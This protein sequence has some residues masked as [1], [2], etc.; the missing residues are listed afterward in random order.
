MGGLQSLD[1]PPPNPA[2]LREGRE[3]CW[4]L[5]G[6]EREA[7]LQ[8]D[9]E[10]L[11]TGTLWSGLSPVPRQGISPKATQT[12]IRH[13]V[14]EAQPHAVPTGHSMVPW[15]PASPRDFLHSLAHH[16]HTPE[17]LAMGKAL[18]TCSPV[19]D[20]TTRPHCGQGPMT[21][22]SCPLLSAAAREQGPNPIYSIVHSSSSPGKVC[23]RKREFREGRALRPIQTALHPIQTALILGSDGAGGLEQLTC[24]TS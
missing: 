13:L 4:G 24:L 18:V 23:A 1:V 22:P 2:A 8:P 11:K 12:T 17:T 3:G 6:L 20:S 9:K 14:S 16:P 5:R 7:H 15:R 10:D 19:T 21:G